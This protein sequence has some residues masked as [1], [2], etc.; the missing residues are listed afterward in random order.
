MKKVI[1]ITGA[2]DGIGKETAK[3]LAGQGH[4]LILHGRNPQKLA[5]TI[6]EIK[7]LTNAKASVE[8][9]TADLLSLAEVKKLAESIKSKH[10]VIDVLINNAGAQF[11]DKRETSA[12]GHEKTF[13]VNLFAPFL[14]TMELMPLLA[15]SSEGR[16]VTVSSA[17][18]KMGGRPRL[19]DFE[20]EHHY[21]MTRAYAHSKLYV[22]WM[23][24]HFAKWAHQQGYDNLTFITVHPGSAKSN[25]Q[26]ESNRLLWMRILSFVW[27]IFTTSTERGAWSSVYA[28]T[29]DE[30]AGK[31]NLY[32]GP[33]GMEHPSDKYYSEENELRVWQECERA[34]QPF[35]S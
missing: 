7:T 5:V 10:K 22:I 8:S 23:M 33:K 18:H 11:A 29:E 20:L 32:I 35:L 34:V 6:E 12:D 2:S 13:A 25:L 14:L 30:L 15:Q 4:H 21:T 19:D 17:S 31:T 3:A 9:Y 16:V 27:R 28:A 1:V 26:R 24:R